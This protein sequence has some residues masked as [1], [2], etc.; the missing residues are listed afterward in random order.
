M[1]RKYPDTIESFT[2]FFESAIEIMN[3]DSKGLSSLVWIL[4]EFGENIEYSPYIIE[5]LI[6]NYTESDNND[7]INSILLASCK[8]FFKSPGEMQ[9]ILAKVF[10]FIFSNFIDIDLKDRASY[11]YNLM[12]TDLEE[13]EY[14]ICGERAKVEEFSD[15]G[16][17]FLAKI[18]KEFNSLSVIYNKPEEKFIKKYISE[19]DLKKEIESLQENNGESVENQENIQDEPSVQEPIFEILNYEKGSFS[20]KAILSDDEFEELWQNY[21]KSE[22]KEFINIPEEIDVKEFSNYLAS[23]NVFVKNHSQDNQI[24]SMYLYSQDVSI[25]YKNN[26]S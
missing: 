6:D 8:L 23:E 4:G 15:N 26:L 2:E 19:E 5:D 11:Y 12:K 24:L 13:A 20:G 7:L 21:L 25:F 10:N 1:L 9:E 18:F 22:K 17:N 14:I 16:N 3:E